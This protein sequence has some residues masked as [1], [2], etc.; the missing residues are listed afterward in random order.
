MLAMPA[1]RADS[2]SH[3]NRRWPMPRRRC[4]GR[5]ASSTRWA[6]SSP[7]STMAKPVTA[8]RL[9]ALLPP[10]QATTASVS[11]S[12]IARSTRGASYFQPSPASMKSRDISAI[13]CA[14]RG[15]ARRMA[16]ARWVMK[17]IV[18]RPPARG[19]PPDA[20]IRLGYSANSGSRNKRETRMDE[21]D[22]PTVQRSAADLADEVKTRSAEGAASK[23]KDF[24]G[25]EIAAALMRLS[26]AFAQD[27]LAALPD[28]ARERALA[29]VPPE[30]AGQ[31]QKNSLYDENT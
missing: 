14:S 24:G 5:T 16:M 23:L 4:V 8:P 20:L 27:V 13:A 22:R 2:S 31:W 19:M 7:S 29:A 3:S 26:P 11:R 25:A 17:A 10:S 15:S 1:T 28:E 30:V 6:R 9:A 12:R 18:P 21:L